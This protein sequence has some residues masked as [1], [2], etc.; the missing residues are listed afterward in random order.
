MIMK[1]IVPVHTTVVMDLSQNEIDEIII[2][3][4]VKYFK[5][6][7]YKIIFCVYEHGNKHVYVQIEKNMNFVYMPYR[8][9]Y[10]HIDKNSNFVYM[11]YRHVYA[12]IDKNSNFFYMRIDMSIGP[13]DKC[14]LYAL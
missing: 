12:H 14:C 1:R 9:V 2:F 13:I 11:R 3:C 5:I 8:H 7:V 10:A 4:I 6:Y